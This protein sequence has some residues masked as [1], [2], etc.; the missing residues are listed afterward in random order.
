MPD[1]MPFDVVYN[2]WR[3]I[4]LEPGALIEAQGTIAVENYRPVFTADLI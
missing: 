3:Q 1:D 2:N 4:P